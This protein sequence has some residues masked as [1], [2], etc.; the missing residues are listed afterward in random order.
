M[1]NK[2]SVDVFCVGVRTVPSISTVLLLV[3]EV[4]VD[5]RPIEETMSKEDY[6]A[7]M[8]LL[9]DY[10]EPNSSY[11]DG[12]DNEGFA[13]VEKDKERKGLL[14]IYPGYTK[15]LKEM[16]NQDKKRGGA[17]AWQLEDED[18]QWIREFKEEAARKNGEQG[19]E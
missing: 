14:K 11:Y 8:R 15:K 13:T 5:E 10:H 2:V 1:S 12:S 16:Y 18:L 17:Y 19:K 4:P 9:D 3:E 6:E 7:F